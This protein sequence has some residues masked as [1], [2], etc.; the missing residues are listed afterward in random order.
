MEVFVKDV[1]LL[2]QNTKGRIS[3]FLK[4]YFLKQFSLKDL[5]QKGRKWRKG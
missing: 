2:T 5:M 3:H 4:Q 1:Q